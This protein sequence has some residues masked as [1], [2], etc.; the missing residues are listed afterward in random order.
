MTPPH[1]PWQAVGISSSPKQLAELDTTLEAMAA[2][3]GDVPALLAAANQAGRFAPKPGEGQTARL[4]ELL[5]SVAAIDVAAGRILEPHLDAG[6]ILSQARAADSFT[7]TWGV[8]AAEAPGTRLTAVPQSGG[9]PSDGEH[10]GEHGG[11][12][13]SGSKPWCSRAQFVDH[14]VGTAHTQSGGRAAFAIDLRDAGVTC[15]DPEWT[16]RGLREIPSGTVHFDRV[17]AVPLGGDGWYFQRPGFAWGGMG[18]AACWL[19]GAVAL[20]RHFKAALI[21]GAQSQREPD[22]VALA[23]L[24]EVDRILTSALQYLARTAELIDARPGHGELP[25][26]PGRSSGAWSEALRV[27]GTVAA[28]VERVQLLVSQNLGPGPLAFDERYGKCMADLSLYVRQHH[29]LRDDA[30]L[31]ALTLK[32]EH[33]W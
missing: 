6:A 28:A 30:Q 15:V 2:A 25:E 10:G 31:G 5:A 14:A 27:R 13:L 26:E 12:R 24:G 4:W 22:Q 29:A 33:E 23:S 19:G 3:V 9:E 1:R 8:F 18:V 11:V 21:R 7:G 32:G 16:S 20:G 17:P